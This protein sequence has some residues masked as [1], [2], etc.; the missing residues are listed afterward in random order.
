M[1]YIQVYSMCLEAMDLAV[2]VCTRVDCL[3]GRASI[4]TIN[5]LQ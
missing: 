4:D 2:H 5:L 1:E 3:A